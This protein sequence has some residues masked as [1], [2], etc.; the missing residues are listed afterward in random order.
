MSR[1][2]PGRIGRAGFRAHG[3]RDGLPLGGGSQLERRPARD[4]ESFV[5]RNLATAI[6]L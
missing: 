6:E 1:L 4:P 2:V 5:A 3:E